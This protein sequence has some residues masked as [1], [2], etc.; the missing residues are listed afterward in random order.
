M[1]SEWWLSLILCS[2]HDP[3]NKS[4]IQ[5]IKRWKQDGREEDMKTDQKRTMFYL[6]VLQGVA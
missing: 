4:S 1:A 6:K 5:K 3:R 2:P